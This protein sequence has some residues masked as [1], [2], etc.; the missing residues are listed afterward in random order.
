L[1]HVKLTELVLSMLQGSRR[2]GFALACPSWRIELK[3]SKG[4][5]LWYGDVPAA[6]SEALREI[7]ASGAVVY[8]GVVDGL[9][10][11]AVYCR[12]RGGS[13]AVIRLAFSEKDEYISIEQV[14][15]LQL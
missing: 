12:L 1:L 7:G 8:E 2:K 9:H 11:Y 5:K 10:I 3:A 6:I 4:A 14:S 15:S 13:P